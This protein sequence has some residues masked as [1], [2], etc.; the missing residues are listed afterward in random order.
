MSDGIDWG[1][2]Y[3]DTNALDDNRRTIMK[4]KITPKWLKN[5]IE[6]EPDMYDDAS[7]SALNDLLCCPLCGCAAA[8]KKETAD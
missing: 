5:K 8:A 4:T 7:E 6:T 1:L 2:P 3:V